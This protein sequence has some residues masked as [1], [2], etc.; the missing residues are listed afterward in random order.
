MIT[1]VRAADVLAPSVAIYD[2]LWIYRSHLQQDDTHR[3][4]DP[5]SKTNNRDIS[6]AH[7]ISHQ[8]TH[9]GWNV[10]IYKCVRI[11]F[12][13]AGDITNNTQQDL[14]FYLDIPVVN[15][16]ALNTIAINGTC[17]IQITCLNG[18]LLFQI[19]NATST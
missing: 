10:L 7:C 4:R 11:C 5:I 2:R 13:Q 18:I 12:R 1:D 6:R 16:H 17:F 8:Q 9:V 14:P 19:V 3:T 15:E